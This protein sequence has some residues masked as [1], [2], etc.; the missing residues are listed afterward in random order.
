M[1]DPHAQYAA[2][3]AAAA[4]PR[5]ALAAAASRVD[6]KAVWP[7]PLLGIA[8]VALGTGFVLGVLRAP[9]D[10]PAAPLVE[11]RA[12]VEQSDFEGAIK[13]LN[14][15][16][17]TPMQQG[18]LTA[19]QQG[20]FYLLRARS[21]YLGQE[22]LG[23]KRPEN[24]KA[25][26]ADFVNAERAGAR[27]DPA[28]VVA[29]AVSNLELG[30]IDAAIDQARALPE[31][32]AAR[33][34]DLF[35]RIVQRNLASKDMHYEQTLGL[36]SDLSQMPGL[37]LE[38]LAW[39]AARQTELRLAAGFFEEAI[40]RLLRQL[41]A[42]DGLRGGPMGE[43]FYLLGQAYYDAG[44]FAT[45]QRQLEIAMRE[46]PQFDPLR[47]DAMVLAARIMQAGNQVES[48]R[49]LFAQVYADFPQARAALPA[50][51][52]RA[53]T[54]AAMGEDDAAGADFGALFEQMK[55]AGA[56]RDLSPVRIGRALLDRQADRF[57]R[58]DFTRALQ[59]ALLA[60]AAFRLSGDEQ[61]VPPEAMLALA[62]SYRRLA[63]RTLDEA[64]TTDQGRVSIDQVSPVTAAEAKRH[65]LDAGA[66]FREHARSVVASDTVMYLDSLWAAADSFDAA[67]DRDAAREAFQAYLDGAPDG[68]VRRPEAKFRLAQSFQADRQF[69]T[70]AAIYRELMTGRLR[71]GSSPM[72]DAVEL[73][74]G[75]AGPPAPLDPSRISSVDGLWADRSI[76]PLARCALADEE[77][78]N[79]EE[80][81]GLLRAVLSGSTFSPDAIEYRDAVTELGEH[82][83]AQD[84]MGGEEG[85]IR[86]LDEAVQRY[87]DHPRRAALVYKLA[88][89]SR[90]LST[91][92]DAEL[93]R[94]MPAAERQRLL[95]ERRQHLSSALR[96]FQ[97]VIDTVRAR[98]VRMVTDL[99]R[100]YQRNATFYIA[101]CAL[102]LGDFA[103]AIKQYDAAAQAYAADAS[104][105]VARMQIV[106]AYVKQGKWAEAL[107]ANE[108]AKRQLLSLPDGAFDDPNLPMQRRHWESWLEAD[109]LLQQ[110]KHAEA[111]AAPA[112]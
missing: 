45:A 81:V 60:H 69:S 29:R 34:I 96:L 18:L 47:A 95:L 71:S 51:L 12:L 63:E 43:L 103:G 5:S 91:Q 106:R 33:R 75:I 9:K 99:D 56:R 88:D 42:L 87:P 10:D 80:A 65:F 93:A 94:T 101:D 24:F 11:V 85:A 6:W 40:T 55:A 79:D 64:R 52:G 31:K 36:L 92:I 89:A 108:R 86:L 100:L 82:A 27:L 39:C 77:T 104:S 111:S 61:A 14:T 4:A 57:S 105:L 30:H 68:D 109:A 76:V 112:R 46:L 67:A 1:A 2:P 41:P 62:M 37:P 54:A 110:R 3:T 74:A 66:A 73:P 72:P 102:E 98:P 20:E 38:D 44:A 26:L 70:A 32:D 28:D 53:E 21:I 97:S 48:A 13:A 19:A 15:R 7:V 58:S 35:R 59:Y 107:T 90:R 83:Y 17:V 78:A 49:E 8:L 22:K 25:V 23:V 84:R 16:L 50:L